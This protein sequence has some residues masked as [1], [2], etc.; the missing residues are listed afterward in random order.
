M[1]FPLSLLFSRLNKLRS[2]SLSMW[3]RCSSSLIIFVTLPCTNHSSPSFLGLR[4]PRYSR[5]GLFWY[6]PGYSWSSGL[7]AHTAGLFQSFCPPEP[8]VLLHRATLNNSYLCTHIWDCLN[9]SAAPH[10][11]P[12]WISLGSRGHTSQA[13]LDLFVWHLFLLLY[14]LHHSA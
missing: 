2:L 6:S 7:Q 3:E 13:C 12:F 5:Y 11:W 1:R 9:P 8:Q 10:S 14:Q 4:A